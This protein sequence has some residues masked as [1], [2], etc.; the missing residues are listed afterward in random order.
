MIKTMR[1]K[2]L[3]PIMQFV[4]AIFLQLFTPYYFW[5]VEWPQ[6]LK[7]DVVVNAKPA[8]ALSKRR[9]E[10][11]YVQLLVTVP[12]AMSLPAHVLATSVR[13]TE[14]ETRL[15]YWTFSLPNPGKYGP[16][17]FSHGWGL[18]EAIYFGGAALLCYWVGCR[19]DA[20]ID[21]RRGVIKSR[22]RAIRITEMI[23]SLG[24]A[25]YLF[26]VCLIAILAY[27]EAAAWLPENFITPI[28]V[29]DRQIMTLGL[30]W[31]VGLLSYFFFSLHQELRKSG[32]GADCRLLQSAI[33]KG[34]VH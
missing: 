15:P 5:W 28:V 18:P 3:L 34:R 4:M 24:M 16:R 29:Q 10:I 25:L 30:A 11:D 32:A 9:G 14:W 21:R 31:P 26:R 23:G 19:I 17:K 6:I 1:M 2:V 12:R 20:L 27:Y 33:P 22:L 8:P 13:S 7:L